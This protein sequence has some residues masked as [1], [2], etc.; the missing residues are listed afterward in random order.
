[1]IFGN[2][3]STILVPWARFES[4]EVVA[5]CICQCIRPRDQHLSPQMLAILKR[6]HVPA[7]VVSGA[8]A[9]ASFSSTLILQRFDNQEAGCN[10]NDDSV[11]LV[12]LSLF[13]QRRAVERKL[14]I[15][16]PRMVVP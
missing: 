2:R 10:D 15:C 13:H 11:S 4:A 8:S 12:F 5:K 3:V 7:T 9:P 14:D 16:P 1:M 6:S